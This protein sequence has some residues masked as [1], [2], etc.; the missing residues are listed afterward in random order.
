MI[1]YIPMLDCTRLILHDIVMYVLSYKNWVLIYKN[2]QGPL[3]YNTNI[4]GYYY[5]MR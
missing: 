3:I 1:N 4:F 2:V 5:L